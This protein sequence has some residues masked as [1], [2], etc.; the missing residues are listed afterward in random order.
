MASTIINFTAPPT[1]ARFMKST[2]LVRIVAGPVG[3][4]KTFSCIMEIL[5]RALG[6][7]KGPDGYR[8]TRFA[9]VRQTLK[10]LKDTVLKDIMENLNGLVTYKV[11]DQT[12]FVEFADVR[13]EWILIPLEDMEDQKRLLSSQLTGA[14][15]S[16]AI[17]MDVNLTSAILGRC[18]RYPSALQ[19]GPT[20]YGVIGDTNFPEE[21]SDWHRVM[22][23]DTP[24]NWQIF[25]QPS[26]LAP[27]AENIANLPGGR[28]YYTNLM[29]G[30]TDGWIKRY[31]KAEYGPD[32]SGSAVFKDSFTRAFHVLFRD[33]EERGVAPVEGFPLVVAQD[34]GRN[35]CSLICQVDHLGRGRVLQ[36]VIGLD[37]GLERHIDQNLV[38]A[39]SK[40]PFIGRPVYMI[41]DPS[42]R[43]KD[44]LAEISA[45]D[46]LKSKRFSV[47]P[48]PTN[49]I[50][51]RIR[52]VESL[53]MQQRQG[54]PALMIDGDHC[55][56]LVQAL[57]SRY[58]FAR[59]RSGQLNAVPE[60]LHPW[61]DLCDDL[62]YFCLII[63]GGLHNQYQGRL[64]TALRPPQAIQMPTAAWT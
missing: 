58:K 6:Q 28:A 13:S 61:S 19:G 42:G 48:A 30:A 40:P 16:E 17:E 20:W 10:Q 50:N 63:T 1:L 44:S 24:G 54:G 5:R 34:F 52:A 35:P 56:M 43:A 2:A 57:S 4:G 27:D 29:T 15:M 21:G 26:G 41:G 47:F 3:S 33:D 60:K 11:T 39:L 31:V 49:D 55:P 12:V 23:L 14:W 25:K 59:R 36:E 7:A 32:P 38:P 9:I 62:Q 45:F 8:H 51:P 64:M 53:F 22:E 46:L 18:G 37:T